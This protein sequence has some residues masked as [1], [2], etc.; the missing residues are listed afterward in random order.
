MD[1]SD[2]GERVLAGLAKGRN[3]AIANAR[4]RAARLEA[5][6]VAIARLDE[7]LGFPERGRAVRVAAEMRGQVTARHVRRILA[8][9]TD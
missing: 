3:R 7:S 5:A 9:K 8:T 1:V 4:A 6:V 2:I